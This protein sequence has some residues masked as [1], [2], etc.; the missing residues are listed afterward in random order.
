MLSFI[1]FHSLCKF[2]T[3]TVV[4]TGLGPTLIV[5]MMAIGPGDSE[6]LFS[7]GHWHRCS[8]VSSK[9]CDSHEPAPAVEAMVAAETLAWPKPWVYIPPKSTATKARPIPATDALV[10]S[11]VLQALNLRSCQRK[12][13]LVVCTAT[14]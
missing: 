14:R 9:A 3:Y 8:E 10:L 2:T 11:D 13:N 5:G 6:A 12:C 7:P 4:D 1:L